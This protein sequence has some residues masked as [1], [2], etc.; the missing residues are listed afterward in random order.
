MWPGHLLCVSCLLSN[1]RPI[2]QR[3]LPI[4]SLFYN[5]WHFKTALCLCNNISR[6]IKITS[7]ILNFVTEICNNFLELEIMFWI[8]NFV[9]TL[10]IMFWILNFVLALKIMFWILNF[11][12]EICRN[13]LELK[14]RFCTNYVSKTV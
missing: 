14:I 3:L 7:M 9:L 11:V 6:H 10:K 5:S 4:H 8:L 13:F 1:N 12:T 2:S